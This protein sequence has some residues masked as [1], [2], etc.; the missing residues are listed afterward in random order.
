MTPDL[1]EALTPSLDR[2]VE[3]FDIEDEVDG[4]V[5]FLRATQDFLA[6]YE[7]E[8]DKAGIVTKPLAA[9][10]ALEASLPLESDADVDRR[11]AVATIREIALQL[12]A[13]Q[14]SMN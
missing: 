6:E 10:V 8:L 1:I 5:P 4:R 7:A 2:V 9:L 14:A 11:A 13:D 12:H 3:T